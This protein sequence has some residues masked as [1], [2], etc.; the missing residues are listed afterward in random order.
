[1]T[2]RG[3]WP[4]VILSANF[5]VDTVRLQADAG[6]EVGQIVTRDLARADSSN[7]RQ[8]DLERQIQA[9]QDQIAPID[10]DY[11]GAQLVQAY[12]ERMGSGTD[13]PEYLAPIDPKSMLGTLDAIRSRG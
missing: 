4:G 9:L 3:F 6:I 8:A 7:P 10:A 5:N 1:M 2:L 13:A 11:K 12:L